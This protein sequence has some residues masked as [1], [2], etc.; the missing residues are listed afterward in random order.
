MQKPIIK[1]MMCA[2]HPE[3]KI[4]PNDQYILVPADQ[5]IVPIAEKTYFKELLEG[6]L[7]AR[8]DVYKE[9]ARRLKSDIPKNAALGVIDAYNKGMLFELEEIIDDLTSLIK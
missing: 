3:K 8:I 6:K 7:E 9:K 5:H 2:E 4:I 1:G